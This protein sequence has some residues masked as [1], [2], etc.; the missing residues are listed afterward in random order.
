M[1]IKKL[2]LVIIGL[3][4]LGLG[5]LGVVLP[6]LPTV[7]LLMLTAFCFASSSDRLN[8]WFK[9]TSL[10]RKHLESFVKS[11]G[12]TRRS[13]IGVMT[14]ITALMGFGFYMMDAAPI[15]RIVLGI[16]WLAHMGYFAFRVKTL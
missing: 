16:V 2:C 14:T 4:S 15:G 10:Y 1:K 3:I 5:A 6:F 12:M 11:R 13:K 8:N 9:S 7:P